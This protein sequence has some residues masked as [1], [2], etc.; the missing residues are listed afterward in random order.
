[1]VESNTPERE[2]RADVEGNAE[3][4]SPTADQLMKQIRQF[5]LAESD[6]EQAAAAA[7]SLQRVLWSAFG[8]RLKRRLPS[9][10]PVPSPKERILTA[11]SG[12][13]GN[14]RRT[15]C[16][17]ASSSCGTPCTRTQSR[18]R[19]GARSSTSAASSSTTSRSRRGSMA[20][21]TTRS[22]PRSCSRL[23]RLRRRDRRRFVRRRT[24]WSTS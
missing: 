17:G 5:R 8:A 13:R 12:R 15:S 7:T 23:S 16:T 14:D 21:S 1:M 18:T 22:P 3:G 11:R 2:S 10:T 4:N 24:T 20:S 9:A 6:M 19:G